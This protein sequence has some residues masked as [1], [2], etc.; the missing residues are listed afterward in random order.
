MSGTINNR[1][2][3]LCDV[4]TATTDTDDSSLLIIN[5]SWNETSYPDVL[6]FQSPDDDAIPFTNVSGL[7]GEFW[8]AKCGFQVPENCVI[9]NINVDIQVQVYDSSYNLE[10]V[11][12][13]ETWNN[14]TDS[15]YNGLFTDISI[16]QSQGFYL[17]NNSV[18]DIKS[19][20]RDPSGDGLGTYLYELK[21]GFQLGYEWWQNITQ[22]AKQFET[23][24]TQYWAAYSQNKVVGGNDIQTDGGYAAIKF[25]ITWDVLDNATGIIT[26]FNR[27]CDVTVN[28]AEYTNA[29]T[30]VITTEDAV[31]GDDLSQQIAS[32]VQTTIKGTFS[33]TGIGVAPSGTS[34]IGEMAVYYE[35]GVVSRYDRICT[36]VD[37][38]DDSIFLAEPV[39]T[40]VDADTITV[41]GT[42]DPSLRTGIWN[43]MKNRMYVR[44]GYGNLGL[45]TDAG[46]QILADDDTKIFVD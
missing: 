1:I 40:I 35:D 20:L 45:L 43:E 8:Y 29:I 2:A 11:F 18:F 28:D 41:E 13:I 31:Y 25:I 44:F 21:Y 46:I 24:R 38:L 39:V 9:N 23:Y 34:I 36:G 37:I 19:I 7:I 26:Q 4:N 17:E 15:F 16:I 6:F 30:G 10:G 42:V 22:F 32:D 14:P 3:V 33:G 5:T 27:S 12:S